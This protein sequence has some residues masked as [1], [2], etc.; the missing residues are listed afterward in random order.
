MDQRTH[1]RHPASL[2]FTRDFHELRRGSL[3][4][5]ADCTILYDPGRIMPPGEPYR[6]GDPERP[7][8]G[9]LRFRDGGPVTD[10]T[11]ES[12]VGLLD[13]VPVTLKADG[14]MLSATFRV[15]DDAQ[16]IMAWFTYRAVDGTVLYDSDDGRNH[17]LRFFGEVDLLDAAIIPSPDRR[18]ASFRCRV[19]AT[20]DVE[21]VVVRYHITTSP[22][23]NEV[24]RPM[25]P[26]GP[27]T[28]AGHRV[29]QLADEQVPDGA[30]LAFDLIYWVDGAR[31]KEDNQGQ[32]F[33]A[34][35]APA[36]AAPA[37][38]RGVPASPR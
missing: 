6:F 25:T 15:P 37:S 4:R 20:A 16:W 11:L 38:T 31:H 1:F 12:R 23:V 24:Q 28:P 35:P 7:V 19:E 17:V 32:Y 8:I 30:T 36:E 27:E 29:W 14:P 34:A 9:H 18:G 10:L 21:A 5:G 26:V 2:L 22:Q 3:E 33:I 13:Y